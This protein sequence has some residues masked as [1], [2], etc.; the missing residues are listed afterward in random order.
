VKSFLIILEIIILLSVISPGGL[1]VNIYVSQLE[2]NK[3]L[4]SCINAAKS[5]QAD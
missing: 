2:P 4:I 5:L 3:R 1:P